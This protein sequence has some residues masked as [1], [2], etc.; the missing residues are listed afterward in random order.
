MVETKTASAIVDLSWT[1]TLTDPGIRADVLAQCA[2]GTFSQSAAIQ[3]LS[4]VAN[5]G[6]VTAAELSSL[7]TIAAQ[8]GGALSASSYVTSV[9]DQLVLGSPMNQTWTGGSATP[10]TLGNLQVGSSTTQLDELIGKWLLGTDL[11]DPNV[12][13]NLDGQGSSAV[14]PTYK[15][16]ALPLFGLTGLPSINDV[17]QGEVGDCVVC[18]A[19][20]EMVVN[21]PNML[22]SMIVNQGNGTYGVRF[23]INGSPDWVTVNSQLPVDSSANLVFNNA[24]ASSDSFWADL[25]EKAYA[26]ASGSGQL[27]HPA[28]NSYN[29]INGNYANIVLTA[30]TGTL[31]QLYNSSSPLW[32]F[33]KQILINDLAI[34]DDMLLTDPQPVGV[35]TTDSAGNKLLIGDHAYAVIGYDANTG[36]FILRNPWGTLAPG[37]TA[38]YETQ[39]EVSMAQ[40]A[41]VDGQIC[42]DESGL[43][44]IGPY[45]AVGALAAQQAGTLIGAAAIT[46]S[47]ADVAGE[48]DQLQGLAK[49]GQLGAITLTDGGTPTLTIAP[50][51]LSADGEVLAAITGSY[52]LAFSSALTVAEAQ[53]L[54]SSPE[55]TLAASFG[56][57]DS[58]ATVSAHLDALQALAASGQLTSITLTNLTI[59]SVTVSAAQQ[60]EDATA[61]SEIAGAYLLNGTQLV[62]P[63]AGSANIAIVEVNPD[64]SLGPV[65]LRFVDN[66]GNIVGFSGNSDLTY[67]AFLW[68][69]SDPS[70]LVLLNPL[71]GDVASVAKMDNAAGTSVGYSTSGADLSTP[72]TWQGGSLAAALP[73]NSGF[74]SGTALAINSAG[75]IAGVEYS[76][77]GH[78][79]VIW[80]N[81]SPEQIGANPG[82]SGDTP[83]AINDSDAVAGVAAIT[84]A[85]GGSS[86][87]FSYQNG[88]LMLLAPLTGD[89]GSGAFGINDAGQVVGYS[90]GSSEH[91]ALWQDGQVT[92]L[93][94][95]A[96]GDQSYA[97]AIDNAGI[98]VGYDF[99]PQGQQAVIWVDGVIY[100]LDSLIP[101]SSGWLLQTARSVD[102]L[103]QGMVLVTG[104][105]VLNGAAASYAVQIPVANLTPT[106]AESIQ[107]FQTGLLS[108]P[109]GISDTASDI[110]AN[111]DSLAPIATAG[112]LAAITLTDPG[113]PVLSMTAAQYAQDATVLQTITGN[114]GLDVSGATITGPAI[115]ASTT[116]STLSL[117]AGNAGLNGSGLDVLALGGTSSSSDRLAANEDGSVTL[118]G[119]G[120]T[121]QLSGILQI[122]FADKTVTIEA[123]NSIDESVAL[124]YQA[125][126]G[127]TPDASGLAFW[128]RIAAALPAAEQS[129]GIYELSDTPYGSASS[130]S[131]AGAFTASPEFAAKYGNLSDN[132][133]VTQLY[134]NVLDRAPDSAGLAF[135]LAQL[136]SGASRDHLL[137]AFANSPEAINNAAIG[138]TGQSGAHA[139][140][141]LLT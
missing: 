6:A 46:D 81:R 102:Q 15:A 130:L 87:G 27:G 107:A 84:T 82:S 24:Y 123:A 109:I 5:R 100:S 141:L 136:S 59:P 118:S 125:A 21:H 134:A 139:A 44:P 51:Q 60:I 45:D 20:I 76:A 66:Q 110:S 124:L 108:S 16:I 127:R 28:V 36:D 18:A 75:D 26:E 61:L 122:A 12:P 92:N 53:A 114:F 37:I 7:Q 126:F 25:I 34:G 38:T 23:T 67:Q 39:F 55:A 54:S 132:Q 42:V 57:A 52:D 128:E 40:I 2:N 72:V 105:G 33:E 138:F 137:V 69:G 68:Q 89:S 93:G 79:I 73:L 17:N 103:D 95:L 117:P 9:Y 129:L 56:V 3:I 48:L 99:N 58:A 83:Y 70:G 22:G 106:A 113:M 14:Y 77:T 120:A 116:Q 140:W 98:V 41:A 135:W 32:S 112:K 97:Y 13:Q 65:N 80:K 111:L 63:R 62:M 74:T 31:T 131:I 49:I 85:A 115:S 1:A 96:A 11:P 101:N 10:V 94:S 50:A 133:Y 90:L 47:A 119:G 29:N 71:P 104:S 8:L 91:A 64:P 19:M 30:F 88:A 35:N 121:H 4:D 86:E 43:L 78:S